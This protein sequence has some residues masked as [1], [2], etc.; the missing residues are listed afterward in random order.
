M[1]V[2]RQVEHRAAA[3]VELRF[4]DWV[5]HDLGD[6][7]ARRRRRV[8]IDAVKPAKRRERF[9]ER[10]RAGDLR[11]QVPGDVHLS[12][13]RLAKSEQI[14]AVADFCHALGRLAV[15]PQVAGVDAADVHAELYLYRV[16]RLHRQPGRRVGALDVRRIGVGVVVAPAVALGGCPER[17]GC[18]RL[19]GDAVAVG[20]VQAHL[21]LGQA[22]ELKQPRPAAALDRLRRHAVGQ[23]V[24]G[25]HAGDR[26]RK[27]DADPAQV[28]GQA[29]RR[30]DRRHLGRDSLDRHHGEARVEQ[31]VRAGAPLVEHDHRDRVFALD[32]KLPW[33]LQRVVAAAQRLRRRLGG[34]RAV[35]RL[36]NLDIVPRH[37]DAVDVGDEPV[38]HLGPQDHGGDR[39]R[40]RGVKLAPQKKRIVAAFHVLQLGAA[41]DLLA[42]EH[43][44]RG[45][46]PVGV[47]MGRLGPG[48]VIGAARGLAAAPQFPVRAVVDQRHRLAGRGGKKQS[49]QPQPHAHKK[50]RGASVPVCGRTGHV[51]GTYPIRGGFQCFNCT[52]AIESRRA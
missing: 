9:L 15:D 27:G 46:L 36:C 44:R 32:Q 13:G 16:E 34:R 28:R 5:V 30:I 11:V 41:G 37:L 2:L 33:A 25:V 6:H 31:G 26:L 49:Q 7:D 51:P 43:R 1:H 17:V 50:A 21:A 8:G 12:R 47:V 22:A 19:V 24:G 20:P 14:P 38:V 52:I 4:L 35:L 40:I 45:G 23:Q 18:L 29:G 10:V 42:E 3:L 48:P 39:V